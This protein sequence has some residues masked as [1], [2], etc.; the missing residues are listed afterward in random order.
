MLL[1]SSSVPLPSPH[2]QVMHSLPECI[3]AVPLDLPGPIA[4]R[5]SLHPSPTQC[6]LGSGSYAIVRQ[7]KDKETGEYYALKAVQKQPLIARGMLDRVYNEIATHQELKH[8]NILTLHGYY[9]DCT[10]IY[11]QLELATGGVL[12]DWQVRCFPPSSRVPEQQAAIIFRQILSAVEHLHRHNIAHRDLKTANVLIVTLDIS[13]RLC[14][15]GWSTECV[16]TVDGDAELIAE[17]DPNVVNVN[18]R[19]TICGTVDSMP[20]EMLMGA[21]HGL[22]CDRWALGC[23][24]YALLVGHSPYA[25]S[26]SG[27]VQLAVVRDRILT[28]RGVPYPA[29]VGSSAARDLIHRLMQLN[30]KARMHASTAMEHGWIQKYH[31]VSRDPS[32]LGSISEDDDDE[33]KCEEQRRGG[34]PIAAGM[35]PSPL[36]PS[37]EIPARAAGLMEGTE[38]VVHTSTLA[39]MALPPPL[40]TLTSADLSP[41]ALPLRQ[42][43]QPLA[44]AAAVPPPPVYSIPPLSSGQ[45]PMMM[46]DSYWQQAKRG[47]LH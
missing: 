34:G 24:L 13:I 15:F 25:V 19:H 7:L 8:E 23:L 21:P 29:G 33:V 22:P 32:S 12:S 10:H 4:K 9:E 45:L 30:P 16:G 35:M 5:F 37:R 17:V 43:Q 44:A 14:D 1:P 3:S 31:S 28:S 2:Q 27:G 20:P 38:P 47:N 40:A 26:N 39:N 6:I 18:R 46:M 11:M 41:F 42:Q 36:P